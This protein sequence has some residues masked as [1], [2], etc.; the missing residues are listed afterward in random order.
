[1]LGTVNLLYLWHGFDPRSSQA[2][3]ERLTALIAFLDF[4]LHLT[5]ST[6]VLAVFLHL[7]ASIQFSD[8]F[9]NLT[10]LF[11]LPAEGGIEPIILRK[12]DHPSKS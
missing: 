11:L 3:Q 9:D 6:A 10:V 8:S 2:C 12:T 7:T 5:A 1:M 4:F